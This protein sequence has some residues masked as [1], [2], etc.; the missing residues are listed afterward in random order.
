MVSTKPQRIILRWC[1][2]CVCVCACIF[3]GYFAL[4]Q[5]HNEADAACAVTLLRSI[6]HRVPLDALL[7]GVASEDKRFVAA[8]YIRQ[9]IHATRTGKK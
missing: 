2:N 9:H 6:E 7:A 3:V 4:G 1:T 5:F 8:A